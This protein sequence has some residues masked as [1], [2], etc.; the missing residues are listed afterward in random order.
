LRKLKIA[1]RKYTFYLENVPDKYKFIE[2]IAQQYS[3]SKPAL[4]I[5]YQAGVNAFEN[6]HEKS[7]VKQP[8]KFAAWVVRQTILEM[9][10]KNKH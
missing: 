8:E 10:A 4:E 1:T 6:L 9:Q 7:S 3:N 2:A 5:Y